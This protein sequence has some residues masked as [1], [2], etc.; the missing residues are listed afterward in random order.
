MLRKEQSGIISGEIFSTA[1][2]EL[3]HVKK[4][5]EI[6]RATYRLLFLI[7]RHSQRLKKKDYI[8]N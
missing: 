8:T 5:Q 4:M 6:K 2:D 1:F 3:L 7:C